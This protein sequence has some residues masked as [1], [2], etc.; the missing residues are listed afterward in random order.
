MY[1]NNISN[2]GSDMVSLIS[3][4][5]LI[6][7]ESSSIACM[8]FCLESQIVCKKWSVFDNHDNFMY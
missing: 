8:N 7:K 5:F 1:W 2:S 6:V 4:R 3:L